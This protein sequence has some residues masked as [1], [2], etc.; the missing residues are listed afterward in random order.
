MD[1]FE[2]DELSREYAIDHAAFET[3]MN[4]AYSRQ[5][6]LEGTASLAMFSTVRDVLEG[7]VNDLRVVR[8]NP[9]QADFLLGERYND[10]EELFGN[11]TTGPEGPM[12]EL[13]RVLYGIQVMRDKPEKFY[14]NDNL[15][16]IVGSFSDKILPLYRKKIDQLSY[17]DFE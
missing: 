14:E 3:I 13:K 9:G 1:N 6:R 12:I 16:E 17:G 5:F 8:Q 2:R 4:A 10:L 15:Q 11:R 7:L